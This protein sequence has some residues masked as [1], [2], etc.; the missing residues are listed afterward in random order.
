MTQNAVALIF[1]RD[2]PRMSARIVLMPRQPGFLK[3][4]R[5]KPENVL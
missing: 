5:E 4:T 1:D 3:H 2:E